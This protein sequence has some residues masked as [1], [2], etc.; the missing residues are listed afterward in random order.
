MST[1]LPSESPNDFEPPTRK[2]N[3]LII[4]LMIIAAVSFIVYMQTQRTEDRAKK[5][6]IAS[7]SKLI[8]FQNKILMGFFGITERDERALDQLKS[9]AEDPFPQQINSVIVINELGDA[10]RALREIE[11]IENRLEEKEKKP[12]LAEVLPILKKLYQDVDAGEHALPSVS[13]EDREKL[14]KKLGWMGELALHPSTTPDVERRAELLTEAESAFT[15][16]IGGL[17][18]GICTCGLGLIGLIVLIVFLASGR[19]PFRLDPRPT[20][21]AIYAETFL[22]WLVL[23]WG[24]QML[25]TLDFIGNLPVS[26]MLLSCLASLLSLLA[27]LWPVQRGIPWEEAKHEIGLHTGQHP[28]YEALCGIATW[29]MC[30]PLLF[31]GALILWVIL[32]FQQMVGG[33]G[34][35]GSGPAPHPIFEEVARTDGWGI[36]QILFMASVMAPLVEETM[37]RGVLHRNLREMS[38]RSH[39]FVTFTFSALVNGVIFAIVHPQGMLGVPLLASLA[40]GFSLAR[41][42]RGSLIACMVAH[43]LHNG[44]VLLFV[45]AMLR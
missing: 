30:L 14:K 27:L 33:G 19:A 40:V 2:G 21:G 22:I 24:L 37:F 13:K 44:L 15:L 43:G 20:R 38:R 42:W 4:W 29:A 3:S 32:Q 6:Q 41:E 25:L 12:E 23:F 5:K 39:M 45:S 26:R 16:A 34:V 10:R 35:G 11:R 8:D 28:A 18:G 31:V 9:S 17:L 1:E 36:L 7:H